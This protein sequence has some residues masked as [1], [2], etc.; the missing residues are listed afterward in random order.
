MSQ[1][2]FES[3]R[4]FLP[5]RDRTAMLARETELAITIAAAEEDQLQ[6]GRELRSL[7][8]ELTQLHERLWP[9]SRGHAYDKARRPPAPGPAPIPRAIVGAEPISGRALRRAVLT[10]L[11]HADAPLTLTEIHS[12]LR[13]AGYELTSE[14]PVKQLANALG[15]E[16]QKGRARRTARGTYA[17]GTL[18]SYRR[19]LAAR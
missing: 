2:T 18:S 4:P 5:I 3:G 11:V 10:L 13:L 17:L 12:A 14:Q 16:T 1:R 15:Y 19:R 9:S 7:R 6:R 8:R